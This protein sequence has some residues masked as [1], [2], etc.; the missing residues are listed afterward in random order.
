MAVAHLSAADRAAF[1]CTFL[2]GAFMVGY[3]PD[4]DGC[5]LDVIYLGGR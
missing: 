4:D 1:L 2:S 3:D 5:V